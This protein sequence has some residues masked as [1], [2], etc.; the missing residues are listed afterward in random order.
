MICQKDFLEKY[1]VTE[2]SFS[3][4][5]LEWANLE[6]IYADYECKRNELLATGTLISEHLRLIK[7]VHSLKMR[8]KEPE[9]LIEKI[10]RKKE[11][12][13]SR[14]IT[15]DNYRTE[16]TDLI[17]VRALHLFKDDWVRIHHALI[18][19]WNL[20]EQPVAYIREGDSEDVFNEN[21]CRVVQHKAG[22]RSVHYLV[23]SRPT[24]TLFIAEIQIRTIFEEGWSEID[25]QMRY[26]YDLDNVIL[27][28]YLRVFNRLAG[29]ADEMGAFIKRLKNEL[30]SKEQEFRKELEVRDRDNQKMIKDLESV[31]KKLAA[32]TDEKKKLQ[33]V[34]NELEKPRIPINAG[35][36]NLGGLL[37]GI[38]HNTLNLGLAALGQGLIRPSNQICR[39]CG[40]RFSSTPKA[41]IVTCP[42]CKNPQRAS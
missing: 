7:E 26:P 33:E 10:I 15:C 39:T 14:D 34:I 1:N 28:E 38:D 35:I 31:K 18:P 30:E 36:G 23:E 37:G 41:G 21:E 20:H 29:N 12:E 40:E 8:I 27:S 16:I 6:K 5:N 3:K 32:E 19:I 42:V 17:G 4:T 11:E 9:H 13:P 24:K 25:H 2:E 22:Y